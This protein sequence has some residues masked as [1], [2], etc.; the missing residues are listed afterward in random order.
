MATWRRVWRTGRI[1]VH[2]IFATNNNKC[3]L[4]ITSFRTISLFTGHQP[5]QPCIPHYH[6]CP[7]YHHCC[8]PLLITMI[9]KINSC[10]GCQL[11]LSTSS[12]FSGAHALAV[13]GRSAKWAGPDAGDDDGDD[14]GHDAVDDDV[15]DDRQRQ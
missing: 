5:C 3:V 11:S 14:D 9:I 1:E 4:I 7:R 10:T 12:P 6:R 2:E 13:E 8:P 15:Y